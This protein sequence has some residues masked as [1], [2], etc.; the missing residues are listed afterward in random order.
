MSHPIN[1]LNLKPVFLFG[2]FCMFT[3]QRVNIT[4][5]PNGIYKYDLRHSDEDWGE[6]VEVS[7]NIIVNFYGSVLV[8]EKLPDEINFDEKEL[9]LTGEYDFME[10]PE[11]D[12]LNDPAYDGFFDVK[13]LKDYIEFNDETGWDIPINRIHQQPRRK[14]RIFISQPFTGKNDDEIIKQRRLI[15]ELYCHYKGWETQMWNVKL[16]NQHLPNDPFDKEENF[17]DNQ[18]REFYRFC[19]SVGM[20]KDATDIIIFGDWKHSRG[21][22][23]EHE[24]ISRYIQTPTALLDQIHDTSVNVIFN[25]DLIDFCQNNPEYNDIFE[26]LYPEEFDKM[27]EV[28]DGMN[29]DKEK[30]E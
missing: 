9:Y 8:K 1:E 3:D 20:M 25:E 21:C 18:Q 6:A 23:L 5:L 11:G 15:T 22:E 12:M 29:K 24:I 16:I 10:E 19:R 7:D 28:T 13:T 2:K 26:Q 17:R 14:Y 27:H 30:E 4:D